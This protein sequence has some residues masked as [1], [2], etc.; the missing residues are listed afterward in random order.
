M[1][2][3]PTF[4]MMISTWRTGRCP[5]FRS[6]LTASIRLPLLSVLTLLMLPFLR[7]TNQ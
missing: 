1:M 5:A 4:S 6:L 2:A 7:D 3:E